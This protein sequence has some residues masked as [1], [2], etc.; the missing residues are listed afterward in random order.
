M[1]GGGSSDRVL[2][3]LR[4]RVGAGVA[5]SEGGIADPD[6]LCDA[7][8][9]PARGVR[10]SLERGAGASLRGGSSTRQPRSE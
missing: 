8:A 6:S 1:G 4:G 2:V 9:N 7:R 3:H 10:A 5:P